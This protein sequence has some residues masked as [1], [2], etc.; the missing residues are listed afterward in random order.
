MSKILKNTVKWAFYRFIE[1]CRNKILRRVRKAC[2]CP[3][4]KV[5]WH[6]TETATD[7]GYDKG[8]ESI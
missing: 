3:K 1:L 2:K 7:M 4:Y 6:L 8:L 5:L